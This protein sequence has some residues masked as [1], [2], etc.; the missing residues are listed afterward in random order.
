M[1][2]IRSVTP[3]FAVAGQLAPADMAAIAA[4]GF[5]AIVKNRPEN[6]SPDQPSEAAIKA[7]AEAAGLAFHALPLRG[8]PSKE[9][10]AATAAILAAETGP[11]LAYC[12]SGTRSIMAWAAGQA[13]SGARHPS[14]L[15]ALAEKAGY[16]LAKMR[17]MLE[18]LSPATGS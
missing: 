10:A 16:D 18:N 17:G 8:P 12:R 5:R 14:E 3:D 6:E 15:L 2:L 13:Q 9:E 7:A 11:V 4:A 1:P